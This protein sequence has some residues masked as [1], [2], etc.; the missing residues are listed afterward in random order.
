[1]IQR[2][3]SAGIA[4]VVLAAVLPASTVAPVSV[5]KM[6]AAAEFVF[7]GRVL[8]LEAVRP[9]GS[10]NIFTKV[11]FSVSDILKGDHDG[12]TVTLYFMGG[13]MGSVT[14]SIGDLEMPRKGERGIYFV[15]SR[16]R[17]QV[18]PLY[19]WN[20]GRFL[21]LK[22]GDGQPRVHTS[23]GKPV[24]ELDEPVLPAT[25][26]IRA[27]AVDAALGVKV[28]T[29]PAEGGSGLTPAEFKRRLR[30]LGGLK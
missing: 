21:I 16:H 27:G 25:A 3:V 15:E 5:R 12:P 29:D 2:A 17:R 18:H 26:A 1:M 28:V 7:E 30:D 10:G 9:E 20:Q 4:A 19:G 23:R 22:G 13:T 14:L 8:G 11:L 6:L 24:L